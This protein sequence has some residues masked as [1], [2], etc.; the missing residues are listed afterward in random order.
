MIY[1][2]GDLEGIITILGSGKCTA[3][4]LEIANATGARDLQLWLRPS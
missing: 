1:S 4:E 2:P 3:N